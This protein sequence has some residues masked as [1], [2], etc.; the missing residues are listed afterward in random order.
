MLWYAYS[1]AY[2]THFYNCMKHSI[3]LHVYSCLKG[4]FEIEV[5][6]YTAIAYSYYVGLYNML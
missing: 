1:H 3:L 6:T 2:Y 4:M 5:L